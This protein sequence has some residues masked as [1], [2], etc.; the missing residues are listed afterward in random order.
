MYSREDEDPH[1]KQWL[2]F[3]KRH[4]Q[5]TSWAEELFSSF[6]QSSAPHLL[7]HWTHGDMSLLKVVSQLQRVTSEDICLMAFPKICGFLFLL[8]HMPATS[9]H[10]E[11]PDVA[12]FFYKV[13]GWGELRAA[14]SYYLHGPSL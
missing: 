10:P 4:L 3:K 2:S 11:R 14:F 13:W 1:T 8:Y 7:M 5:L 9:S 6:S 12:S